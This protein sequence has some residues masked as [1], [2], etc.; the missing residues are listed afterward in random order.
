LDGGS[1]TERIAYSVVVPTLGTRASLRACLD[2][3]MAQTRAPEEVIVV[4]PHGVRPAV[5]AGVRVVTS[6]AST[7]AQ[8]NA[9]VAVATA[10]VILFVD[11]DIMLEPQ[12]GRA[13]CD[14]W[15]RYGGELVGV[16]GTIVNDPW[17][18]NRLRRVLRA[19]AGLSRVALRAPA[20]RLVASG[21]IAFVPFRCDEHPVAFPPAQCI[22]YRRDLL[23]DE[24]F[25]ETFSGYVLGEDLDLGARL[26]RRGTIIFTPHARCRHERTSS[27]LGSAREAAFRRGRM[28][29]YFRGRHRRKG[30]LGRLAWE[31][32]NAAEA[33]LMVL[34]SIRLRDPLIAREFLRGLAET[35]AHLRRDARALSEAI[36]PAPARS[37]DRRNR[38]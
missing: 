29:A 33:A 13:V 26:A 14:V 4:V 22:S 34:R 5:R 12:F 9:G 1:R 37:R 35:H 36:T 19:T 21:H 20:T 3:I 2:R 6:S 23:T 16:V 17:D 24:P 27:G 10:P 38:R 11:D 28:H 25:D 30:A 8:R 18:T 7:S 31:W 15:E 32:A